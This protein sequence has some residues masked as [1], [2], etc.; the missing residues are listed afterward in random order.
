MRLSVLDQSGVVAGRSPDA[1]IRESLALARACE[2]LGYCR[3]WVSEH[4]N[5]EALAGS[6]PEILLG[7]LAT[8]TRSIRIGSAGVMLPHYAPLK[9]AEQF[10]VLDALAPGRI[11]LGIGR[12]PGAD[13]QTSYALRPAMMDNPLMMAAADSFANDVSDVIAWSLTEPLPD[14]HPFAGVRAQP[15]SET[16]PQPWLLGSTP[17]TAS[18]AGHLGLPFCFAH[19]FHD[20]E[21]CAE[22]LDA[23]R[24]HFRP[25]RHFSKP[26]VSLCVWAL[27][28]PTASL[29][30]DLFLPYACW[31]LDRDRMRHTPFPGPSEIAARVLSA[32]EEERI[33]QLRGA[34]IFGEARAVAAQLR[35]LSETFAADEMAIVTMTHDPADRLRSYELVAREMGLSAA[36]PCA[37]AERVQ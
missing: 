33:A 23:Y 35:R 18:L 21:G 31:R 5:N 37:K 34:T 19:F 16:A 3:Y 29:G 22:A 2:E 6:A 28:A 9:V 36:D 30:E 7:A 25:G 32:R 20:G 13:R 26:Y 10:R 4:H 8:I 11:D 12:G 24:A 14:D 27:A 1:S 17:F 15:V